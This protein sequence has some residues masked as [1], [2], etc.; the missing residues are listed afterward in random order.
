V[1]SVT[2]YEVP[3]KAPAAIH[4]Q[5]GAYLFG[6]RPRVE[7]GDT[8]VTVP[9]LGLSNHRI[10][11]DH[12]L[13]SPPFLP[14]YS[15]WEGA[16]GRVAGFRFSPRF[17]EAVAAEVGL[18]QPGLKRF[19]H[20]FFSIDQRLEALCRLLMEET[21][22]QCPHGRRYF[23]AL[24]EALAVGVLRA[25]CDDHRRKAH[26]LAVSS[27]IRRTIERLEADFADDISLAELADLAQLGR[28]HFASKFR[29]ATGETPHQY[30]LRVRLSHARKLMA[31]GDQAMSMAEIAAACGF[32]DQ[33]HMGRLFRRFFG[34]TPGAFR[35]QN[36]A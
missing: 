28:S 18:P 8:W 25:I 35:G 4:P 33:A 27:G 34:T 14:R 7:K 15:H 22:S 9:E 17:F 12:V 21:E 36:R 3:A 26:A 32:F 19:W 31:Q 16:A 1:L 30:L 6:Y 13:V 24:A 23:E 20:A 11:R 5:R 29:Q 2:V 10:S